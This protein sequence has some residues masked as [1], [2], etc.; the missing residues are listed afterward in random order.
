MTVDFKPGEYMRET[1]AVRD[2]KLRDS[3]LLYSCYSYEKKKP[4]LE[5]NGRTAGTR[6]FKQN[7]FQHNGFLTK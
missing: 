1:Q 6:Q 2:K 7:A 5:S 4:M 3:I